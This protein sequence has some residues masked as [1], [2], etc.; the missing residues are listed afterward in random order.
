M[1][2]MQSLLCVVLV[3]VPLG[4]PILRAQTTDPILRK[5]D[6]H[7]NHLASLRAAYTEHYAG[8]GMDRTET[9]TLLLKKPG[10]MRWNYTTPV[11]KVFLLGHTQ[12]DKELDSPTVTPVAAGYR[13]TGVPKGMADR[14]SLL[15]LDVSATGAIEHM[16][17]EETGGATTEFTFTGIEEG[18]PIKPSEFIFT[19]PQGVAIID[20]LPPV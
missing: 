6:D 3:G 20:G 2:L 12:L 5:V 18:I 4:T 13:I 19:P 1:P 15:T 8:M 9:G 16:K 7:Y 11:G 10:R 14:I 17:L